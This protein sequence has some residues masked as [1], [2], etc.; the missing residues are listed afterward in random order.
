MYLDIYPPIT[1]PE[2]VAASIFTLTEGNVN[3]CYYRGDGQFTI[4]VWGGGGGGN[5]IVI[6][7]ILKFYHE[8]KLFK[9]NCKSL[10]NIKLI[11]N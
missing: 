8:L 11:R 1:D 5:L 4:K 9:R 3:L 7:N 10:M 6:C 2:I